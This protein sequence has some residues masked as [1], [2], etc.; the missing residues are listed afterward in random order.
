MRQSKV[1]CDRYIW[2]LRQLRSCRRLSQIIATVSQIC[3]GCRRCDLRLSGMIHGCRRYVLRQLGVR[4]DS[5]RLSAIATFEICDRI[6][7]R[8]GSA[9]S[10]ICDVG[11]LR[12]RGFCD[13]GDL[14]RR[15]FCDVA[16]I[17]ERWLVDSWFFLHISQIWRHMRH[18][19]I[20]SRNF[21]I[22]GSSSRWKS[23]TKIELKL[24]LNLCNKLSFISRKS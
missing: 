22:K 2:D 12:R 3:R 17:R 18:D 20:A 11:D 14:R 15:G 13:V 16:E 6:L 19:V 7:R 4:C 21:A 24:I 1:I 23:W 5:L 8:R 10:G 9:T